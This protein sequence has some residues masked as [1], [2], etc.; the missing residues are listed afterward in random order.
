MSANIAMWETS[1]DV[2][3]W[4]V[5]FVDTGNGCPEKECLT[6]G[7]FGPPEVEGY[8]VML[9]DGITVWREKIGAQEILRRHK[10]ILHHAPRKLF[11]HSM[12]YKGLV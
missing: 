3:S 12:F 4:S 9:S 2:H 7:L 1:A 10:V 11:I 6:K 5:I 8:D